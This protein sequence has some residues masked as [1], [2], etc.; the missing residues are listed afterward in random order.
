MD[1]LAS[2]RTT[3]AP[4]FVTLTYPDTFPAYRADYKRDLELFA[5]RLEH[6]FPGMAI[7]WKLEFKHR[8]SGENAG[9]LAPH[10][11]LFLFNVP[12]SFPCREEKGEWV[13]VQEVGAGE[14]RIWEEKVCGHKRP[15]GMSG[16]GTE[17]EDWDT[18]RRWVS[19]NWFAVVGTGDERHFKAGTRVEKL[20]SYRGAIAYA[21]KNYS[22]KEVDLSD[23]PDR[24]GRFWGKIG[25]KNLDRGRKCSVDLT[26]MQVVWI[27]RL[28]RR[29]LRTR[30]Y[31]NGRRVNATRTG[32]L[33]V[34]AEAFSWQA[35]RFIGATPP[36]SHSE[37]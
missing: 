30:R 14:H 12:G 10:Y 13:Q 18:L 4:W 7:I 16:P 24:P 22:A 36:P 32:R 21:A 31:R 35:L 8:K 28:F 29:Y 2:V 27:R 5:K 25:A 34:R 9:K 3:A 26:P 6:R 23:C 37:P 33:Y 17:S 15:I 1:L 11:H 20:H 19:R